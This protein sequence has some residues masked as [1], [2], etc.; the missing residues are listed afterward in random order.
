MDTTHGL[1]TTVGWRLTSHA[2][3]QCRSRGIETRDVLECLAYAE[4]SVPARGGRTRYLRGDLEVI[5]N[6]QNQ[7]VITTYRHNQVAAIN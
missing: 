5:A 4:A 7:M 6:Q 3:E 1:R 2:R